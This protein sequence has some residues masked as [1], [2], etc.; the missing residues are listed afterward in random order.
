MSTAVCIRKGEL[1]TWS[2]CQCGDCKLVSKR[3]HKLSRNG[4]FNRI[5]SEQ[6]VA[7]L[8][9]MMAADMTHRS[10]ATAVGV[11]PATV[12]G[13]M[14]KLRRGKH[15][16]LGA[17]ACHKLLNAQR[18]TAGLVGTLIPMRM[19]RALARIGWSA[20]EL[21]RRVRR[22]GFTVGA[23]TL[24]TIRKGRTARVH[25]TLANV[26]ADLYQEL[27]MTPGGSKGTITLAAAADWPSTFAWDDITDHREIPVGVHDDQEAKQGLDESAIER[28][29][30]GDRTARLHKGEAVEVVRRLIAAGKSNRAIRRD[31]G[32]KAERYI[33][34]SETRAQVAA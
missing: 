13:W 2:Q 21:T 28:R 24:W 31:Y 29:L 4:R 6:G 14:T 16:H 32:I 27:H 5:P 18:P 8:R 22:R 11:S 19:L 34:V 15:L 30:N 9:Q 1:S 25:A 20:E 23:N 12:S 17:V 33:K 10:I 7:V 26:I 3:L